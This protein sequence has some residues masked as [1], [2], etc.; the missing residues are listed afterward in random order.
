MNSHIGYCLCKCAT[1]SHFSRKRWKKN[2]AKS[3]NLFAFLAE[4]EFSDR[5]YKTKNGKIV[6]HSDWNRDKVWYRER[7][8]AEGDIFKKR[9]ACLKYNDN[10]IHY[11]QPNQTSNE[12]TWHKTLYNL[13]RA[14]AHT[15]LRPLNKLGRLTNVECVCSCGRA[16]KSS[17]L[18]LTS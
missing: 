7:E 5:L 2:S 12:H 10:D 16:Q 15:S 4:K 18:S 17:I 6:S 3:Q 9:I 14:R 1:Q 13:T 8:K 11:L